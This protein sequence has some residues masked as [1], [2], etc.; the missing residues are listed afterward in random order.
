[1]K[2]IAV[3]AD[4]SSE[5]GDIS[6][7]GARAPQYL[8]YSAEGK[9]SEAVPNP[10]A[11]GGG[12]AGFSVAKMLADKGVDVFVAGEIGGNMVEALSDRG[13]RFVERTGS[14][15]EAI[16]EVVGE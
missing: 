12:G 10:F 1:M 9:F 8:L 13:I 2:T 4:R 16:A 15:A 5:G 11:V 14:V 3:A 6:P 7:K